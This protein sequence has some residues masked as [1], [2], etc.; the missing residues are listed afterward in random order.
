VGGSQVLAG[1]LREGRLQVGVTAAHWR[2]V[3][4]KA[5]WPLVRDGCVEKRYVAAVQ[6]LIEEYGPFM[7]LLP[8]IAVLHAHPS[9]GVRELC[10]AVATL[11]TPVSFGH[12]SN[13]PVK[14]A[15]VLGAVDAH[16]H[17]QALR[18]LIG[19]LEDPPMRL[20]AIDAASASELLGI[21]LRRG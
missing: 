12:E 6:R 5:C 7:V 18:E 20:R 3:A 21:L 15:V 8:N 19:V 17:I 16:S 11:K 10:L 13:D 4:E 9:D 2:E 14:L 1:L